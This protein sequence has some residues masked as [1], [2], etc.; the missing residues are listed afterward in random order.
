MSGK[1]LP[2]FLSVRSAAPL[3]GDLPERVG[4]G[5]DRMPWDIHDRFAERHVHGLVVGPVRYFGD[6]GHAPDFRDRQ[7]DV[8]LHA[9]DEPAYCGLLLALGSAIAGDLPV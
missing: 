7:G 8:T 3:H 5:R 4:S 1:P 6:A 9:A 2:V